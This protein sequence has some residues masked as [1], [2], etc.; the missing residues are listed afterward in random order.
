MRVTFI[1]QI[2]TRRTV[3]I[4]AESGTPTSPVALVTLPEKQRRRNHRD[5]F[6]ETETKDENSSSTK[7]LKPKLY[8]FKNSF[9]IQYSK[10]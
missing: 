7:R 9:K 4:S 2:N 1:P 6:R 10:A 5:P 8:R 3:I